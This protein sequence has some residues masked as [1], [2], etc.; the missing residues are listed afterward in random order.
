MLDYSNDELSFNP[1][2]VPLSFLKHSIDMTSTLLYQQHR[3][4]EDD[5]FEQVPVLSNLFAARMLALRLHELKNSIRWYEST[6]VPPQK[7]PQSD[8][9]AE[10]E[11]FPF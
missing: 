7:D 5:I 10:Q 1:E 9:E 2:L 3:T 11:E 6:L 8:C 4:L